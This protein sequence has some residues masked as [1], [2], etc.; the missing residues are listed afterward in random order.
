MV[1]AA[2]KDKSILISMQEDIFNDLFHSKEYH[3]K[4]YYA[5]YRDKKNLSLL[6]NCFIE[7]IQKLETPSVK[8]FV[9]ENSNTSYIYEKIK[10]SFKPLDGVHQGTTLTF[11][12]NDEINRDLRKSNSFA[13]SLLPQSDLDILFES[14]SLVVSRTIGHF[15]CVR[16]TGP[17]LNGP[18]T[19][20]DNIRTMRYY[21]IDRFSKDLTIAMRPHKFRCQ[22]T[23]KT[24]IKVGEVFW[25]MKTITQ[26][27]VTLFDEGDGSV[28]LKEPGAVGDQRAELS[29]EKYLR[30]HL[31][32]IMSKDMDDNPLSVGNLILLDSAPR[33]LEE[34]M[35]AAGWGVIDNED[36][37]DFWKNLIS[38]W[39]GEIVEFK[40]NGVGAVVKF[41]KTPFLVAAKLEEFLFLLPTRCIKK[42]RE[43]TI[44]GVLAT[45]EN[46]AK[47][48]LNLGEANA[49]EERCFNIMRRR[50]SGSFNF[51]ENANPG[52]GSNRHPIGG[53]FID[54]GGGHL[55]PVLE[56]ERSALLIVN[57]QT[58]DRSNVAYQKRL[59]LERIQREEKE[60]QIK[61][62]EEIDKNS[63]PY[64]LD[65]LL[66]K[67]IEVKDSADPFFRGKRGIVER[68]D[69]VLGRIHT[70]WRE[71][72]TKRNFFFRAFRKDQEKLIII[73]D[74]VVSDEGQTA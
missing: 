19:N 36:D 51:G 43:T 65:Y 42:I 59:E 26:K 34:C 73:S 37:W 31:T 33:K 14:I 1:L 40:H 9:K 18:N 11:N 55:R 7:A 29:K 39:V 58:Y 3:S 12:R 23:T 49:L 10:N 6:E 48:N 74:L 32:E 64:N 24:D 70:V 28:L 68:V 22:E 15:V 17:R 21:H 30:K 56:S 66:K 50:L 63:G 71:D 5:N 54:A 4:I 13:H 62:D 44:E 2:E 61:E 52:M 25:D 8:R 38:R 69:N 35:T 20:N 46:N 53:S 47:K 41:K 57:P 45:L 27:E 72:K 67:I 60:K 16:E